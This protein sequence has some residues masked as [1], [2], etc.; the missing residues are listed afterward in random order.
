MEVCKVEVFRVKVCLR[1][2]VYG[3]L[4]QVEGLP[5]TTPTK[6]ASRLVS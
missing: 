1:W 6:G 5:N 3:G 4:S 2:S